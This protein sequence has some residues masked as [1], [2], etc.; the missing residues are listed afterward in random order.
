LLGI[1]NY[2]TSAVDP[3]FCPAQAHATQYLPEVRMRVSILFWTAAVAALGCAPVSARPLLSAH[4]PAVVRE[5]AVA[6]AGAPDQNAHLQL[7]IALPMRHQGELNEL[8]GALYNPQS[9]LFHHWLSV[10]EF[11]KRFGPTPRDYDTA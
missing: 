1:E 8:L 5:H 7:T 2:D 4:V 10:A 6:V 9:P 11:T 3:R